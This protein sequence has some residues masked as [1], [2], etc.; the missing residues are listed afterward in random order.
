MEELPPGATQASAPLRR[1]RAELPLARRGPT[2]G[3]VAWDG[4]ENG[5]V[6]LENGLVT[7]PAAA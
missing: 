1:A 7:S 4:L 2:V 6:D 5:G 3:L